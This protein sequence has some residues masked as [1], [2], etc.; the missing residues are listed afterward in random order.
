MACWGNQA[1]SGKA[2]H[3]SFQASQ[4]MNSEQTLRIVRNDAVDAHG[5]GDL[6]VGWFVD[7]V[8][9]DLERAVVQRLEK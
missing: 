6:D 5:L 8:D 4:V 1:Q 9:E 7:G 2:I 3:G